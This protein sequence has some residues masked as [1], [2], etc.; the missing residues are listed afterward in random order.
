MCVCMCV[1]PHQSQSTTTT[2]LYNQC[3]TTSSLVVEEGGGEPTDRCKYCT[4]CVFETIRP[5][6]LVSFVPSLDQ[7]IIGRTIECHG[8]ADSPCSKEPGRFGETDHGSFFVT[9]MDDDDLRQTPAWHNK[10]CTVTLRHTVVHGSL[11][12]RL[13]PSATIIIGNESIIQVCYYYVGYET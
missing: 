8:W 1:E 4:Q 11:G 6:V 5:V 7:K 12:G 3:P 10:Y 2:K 13:V 9:A